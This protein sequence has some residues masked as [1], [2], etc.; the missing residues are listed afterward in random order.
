LE[1]RP[2]VLGLPHKQA[3]FFAQALAREM[4][5]D[6]EKLRELAELLNAMSAD[7][8]EALIGEMGGYEQPTR[9]IS[10]DFEL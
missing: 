6:M 3:A 1:F 8:R 5:S 10:P 4:N 9:D 7:Q 2:L